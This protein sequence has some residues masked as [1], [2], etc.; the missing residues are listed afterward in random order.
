MSEVNHEENTG[1]VG[2]TPPSGGEAAPPAGVAPA[3]RGPDHF[4]LALILWV[5]LSIIGMV[6]CVFLLP[7]TLPPAAS[8][9]G[10]T[11]NFTIVL[12]TVLAVPVA[13][14]VFVFLAY[15]LIAFR[16]RERQVEDAIPI[17]PRP[18]LQ[19]GWLGVTG[20]LCLFLIIYGLFAFYQETVAAPV[21][22][23][24]VQVTGQQWDWTFYYPQYGVSDSGQELVVPVN[25]P[26]QFV[27][28]SKDVLHGFAIRALGVR[29]DANPGY[30]TTTPVTTPEV[31]GVYPVN[32][33]ELCGLYHS[34]MWAS[35]KVVSQS[36]FNSWI[37]GQGGHP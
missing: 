16:V 13:L 15:S 27:V 14:F 19:I 29:V 12:L 7:L 4:R 37:T 11:D 17:K 10:S 25:R 1:G 31:I 21:N 22:P 20:V 24:L 18:M 28:T 34:Y 5:V 26:V 35:L 3:S 30:T 32:C 8:D 2:P 33:V 23:L 9:L 36:S 6:A